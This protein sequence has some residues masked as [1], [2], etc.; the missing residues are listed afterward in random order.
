MLLHTCDPAAGAERAHRERMLRQCRTNMEL[1]MRHLMT[2]ASGPSRST[3]VHMTAVHVD[4]E[5]RDE[6]EEKR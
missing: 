5:Q 3:S 6:D 2:E 4:V 1:A